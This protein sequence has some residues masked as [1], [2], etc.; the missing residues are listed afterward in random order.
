MRTLVID[1]GT[2][3]LRAAVVN[4]DTTVTDL[5]H[6]EFAPSTPAPGLVEFDAEAMHAAV[7]RVAAAATGGRPVDAVG[8]TNQRASTVG[9]RRSTGLPIGPAI[10]WQDLRTV[11]DCIMARV[12]HGL[13]LAPNQSATK[14]AWMLANLLPD[15]AA[16]ADDDILFGT[17][18]T[19][20]AWKL[21][22]G[23]SHDTDSTNSA[24]TGLTVASSAR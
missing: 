23:V 5:H 21:S 19:W 11:G 8:I 13:A 22:G 6:E 4:D 15:D 24:V 3:G 18:D 17:V 14:I 10:G 12:N 9:W 1:V 20:L 16:R 2:S 7:L